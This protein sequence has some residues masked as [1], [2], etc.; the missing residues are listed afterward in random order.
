VLVA[1]DNADMRR[2]L[3]RVLTD[4]WDVAVAAA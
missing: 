4:R 2:H 3:A 1:D